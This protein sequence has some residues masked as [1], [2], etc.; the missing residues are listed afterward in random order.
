MGENLPIIIKVDTL[1]LI[2]VKKM[3]CLRKEE[4]ISITKILYS[5]LYKLS[6]MSCSN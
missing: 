4:K 1:P 5:E 2:L 3:W 6:P